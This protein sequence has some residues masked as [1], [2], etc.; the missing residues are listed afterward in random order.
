MTERTRRPVAGSAYQISDG[1]YK[2]RLCKVVEIIHK[3]DRDFVKVIFLDSFGHATKD[4]D[5]IP[6]SY[7]VI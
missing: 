7:L 2:G 3:T 4:M 6:A 5:I 1:R